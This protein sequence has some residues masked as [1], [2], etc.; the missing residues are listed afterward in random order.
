MLT[1]PQLLAL[2]PIQLLLLPS[3][4]N[5]HAGFLISPPLRYPPSSYPPKTLVVQDRHYVDVG[6]WGDEKKLILRLKMFPQFKMLKIENFFVTV[7]LSFN[8][9]W[10]QYQLSF[11]PINF[12]MKIQ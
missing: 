12:G 4:V 9:F 7:K 8:S 5:M 2:L 3:N 1:T 6:Y 11:W 10:S